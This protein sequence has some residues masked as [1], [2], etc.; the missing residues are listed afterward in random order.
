MEKM[1]CL[2]KLGRR[3]F[4]I[5]L[6]VKRQCNCVIDVVFFK[7]LNRYIKKEF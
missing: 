4:E 7:G 1:I 3:H 6:G 5:E 2:R